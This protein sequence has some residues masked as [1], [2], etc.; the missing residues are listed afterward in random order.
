MTL[1]IQ[2]GTTVA[3]LREAEPEAAACLD[4]L[5]PGLNQL[6]NPVLRRSVENS[7]T[8]ARAAE[9]AGLPA[10]QLLKRLR[11]VTGQ[12]PTQVLVDG[13]PDWVAEEKVVDCIDAAAMLQT[14]E[15]PIGRVR[16]GA[17]ALPPGGILKLI[18]PFRPAPLLEAMARSGYA[19]YCRE[20][21]DRHEVYIARV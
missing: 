5:V 19:V 15:H 1:T 14:G 2:E 9:W 4:S 12:T 18:A 20:A 10:H 8:L 3:A 13:A 21:G 7:L 17:A 6:V 11:Q 16:Q